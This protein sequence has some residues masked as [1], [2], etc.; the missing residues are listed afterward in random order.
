M[1]VARQ[2]MKHEIIMAKFQISFIISLTIYIHSALD[3]ENDFL[4]I[5]S[6]RLRYYWRLGEEKGEN[7]TFLS[8]KMKRKHYKRD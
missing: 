8:S 4:E 1:A 2:L 5:F 3:K 6:M 7:E